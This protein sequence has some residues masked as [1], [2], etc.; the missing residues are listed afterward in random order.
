TS[1]ARLKVEGRL[2]GRWQDPRRR[3]DPALE[4][5]GQ[6]FQARPQDVAQLV[7]HLAEL[8]QTLLPLF[9]RLRLLDLELL[10][11]LLDG[12][13]LGVDSAGETVDVW[14]DPLLLKLV[15]PGRP[16]APAAFPP[17]RRFRWPNQA[18]LSSSSCR[19]AAFGS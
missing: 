16:A 8:L 3:L 7:E 1:Q 6:E 17:F 10:D 4:L 14:H 2:S 15:K 19:A 11:L 18:L 12:R 13:E 9:M 5:L